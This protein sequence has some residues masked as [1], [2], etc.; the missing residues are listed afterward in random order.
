MKRG[1][2][3]KSSLYEFLEPYLDA[4]NEEA[5]AKARKTYWKNYKALWR[6]NNRQ[7][8]KEITITYTKKEFQTIKT[9]ANKH[10]RS[11]PK[12][13]KES[14]LAYAK[15]HFLIPD[16]LTLNR[17]REILTLNYNALQNLE[18]GD[19]IPSTIASYLIEQFSSLEKT[20]LDQL[21]FPATLEEEIIAD[22]KSNP[23]YKESLIALLQTL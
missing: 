15:K 5:I 14:S 13:I 23:E 19:K 6:Q 3:K 22:V 9:A 21:Q 12:Y 11:C 1:L 4:G 10:K 16:V 20:V 7:E 2:K 18:E 17:I 8:K